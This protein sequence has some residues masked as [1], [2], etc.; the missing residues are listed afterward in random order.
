MTIKYLV[1]PSNQN[2]KGRNKWAI[3]SPRFL[4]SL[5]LPGLSQL[6]AME[7]QSR[8]DFHTTV[9]MM[10]T[11]EIWLPCSQFCNVIGD[12][13]LFGRIFSSDSFLSDGQIH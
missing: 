8:L 5:R 13:N 6:I 7:I 3:E 9:T 11:I 4:S 12:W 10:L 2:L 1:F